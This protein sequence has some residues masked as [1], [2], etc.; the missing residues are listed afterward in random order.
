MARMTWNL[1]ER[2]VRDGRGIGWGMEYLPWLWIRRRNPSPVSNQ[3]AGA[4]LPGLNRECCFLARIEW[5]I[6]LLCFWLGALDVRE[7]F[8]LWPWHHPHPLTGVLPNQT[9]HLPDSIGLHEIAKDAGIDHGRF[10]GSDVPYVATTDLVVTVQGQEGP[11]LAAIPVKAKKALIE[12]EPADRALERLE[13]ERR[14]HVALGNHITVATEELVSSVLGGNLVWFSSAAR[15]PAHLD[16]PLRILEFA[17]AFEDAASRESIVSAVAKVSARMRLSGTDAN[18]FF[19]HC[20]WTR[21]IDIDLSYDVEMTY[22]PRRGSDS[23][24]T[25]LRNE[26]FGGQTW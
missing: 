19:R 7:Q 6:S 20:V 1:L 2:Y 15:L 25:V 11:R 21:L 8:P 22:P 16:N 24:I 4:M 10:V 18:L 13:L 23:L 9:N 3:V 5:L 12:A 17:S 26:L 14:Y